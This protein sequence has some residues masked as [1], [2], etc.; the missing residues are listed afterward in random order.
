MAVTRVGCL[1]LC[2]AGPLLGE[3]SQ[4]AKDGRAEAPRGTLVH[5]Y[6][7]DGEGIA[8]WANLVIATG[9]NN[10]AMNRSALQV[11]RDR[12][13]AVRCMRRPGARRL[14][15]ELEVLEVRSAR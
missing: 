14:G 6:R 11:R 13:G 3:H 9:H 1:G 15:V 2:A 8:Q 5:H 4:F 10:L 12:G 7:V